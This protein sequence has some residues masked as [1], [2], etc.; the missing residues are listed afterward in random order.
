[1][2]DFTKLSPGIWIMKEF[3]SLSPRA[4]NQYLYILGGPH[5]TSAGC[6]HL[7]ENYAYRDVAV[8]PGDYRAINNNLKSIDLI[9]FDTDTSEVLV[10]GWFHDNPPM[11]DKH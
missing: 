11:N 6:Y 7:S 5:Q 2:R 3:Q 10:V 8:K 1:M 9:E 4:R